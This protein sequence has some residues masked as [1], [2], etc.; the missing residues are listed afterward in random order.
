MAIL[1]APAFA[2]ID[3][4]PVAAFHAGD[5]GLACDPNGD[6]SYPITRAE[7][8][9]CRRGEDL[10]EDSARPVRVIEY[11]VPDRDGDGRD[12]MIVLVTTITDYRQAAA[13]TLARAYHERWDRIVAV[14]SRY[15]PK[16]FFRLNQNVP[17][18][19]P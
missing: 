16:N 6:I 7:D 2:V 1:G 17:P 11:D 13:E 15:D 3:D 12:E 9:A 19:R 14:K 10:D 4:Q 18:Q 8:A 5:R